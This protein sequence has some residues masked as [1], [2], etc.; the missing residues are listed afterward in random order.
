MI[1]NPI[2]D[3]TERDIARL[4][5]RIIVAEG[6]WKWTG[7]TNHKGY[8]RIHIKRVYFLAHRL[9]YHLYVG[10]IPNSF[11][12][13]HSCDNTGCTNPEHLFIG[14]EKDNTA[15]AKSKDRLWQP[16]YQGEMVGNS[17]LN[18]ESVRIIRKAEED[19]P[20]LALRFNVSQSLISLVQLGR[21]W[22]HVR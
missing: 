13:C 5:S 11:L 19:Q 17:K 22:R 10:E 1:S 7:V 18:D 4:W 14:T 8:G 16:K 21:I 12:V 3:L 20:S 9:M 15:D 6:C 2:P